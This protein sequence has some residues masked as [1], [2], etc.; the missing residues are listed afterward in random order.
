MSVLL[1]PPLFDEINLIDVLTESCC[2]E[3]PI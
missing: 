1:V 2:L 3:W